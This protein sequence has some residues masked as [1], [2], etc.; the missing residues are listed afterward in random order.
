MGLL[1][2]YEVTAK[3]KFLNA[4]KENAKA[5]A[6]R[7]EVTVRESYLKHCKIRMSRML[8][9]FQIVS[10]KTVKYLTIVHLRVAR[11]TAFRQYQL[12]N[13]THSKHNLNLRQ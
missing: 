5:P 9:P 13:Q 2:Q 3:D 10:M 12:T 8:Q 11:H 4:K 1:Q 7:T 6:Q